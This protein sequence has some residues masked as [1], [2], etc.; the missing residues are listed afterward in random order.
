MTAKSAHSALEHL[1]TVWLLSQKENITERKGKLK[2]WEKCQSFESYRA[3]DKCSFTPILVFKN[4]GAW[5]LEWYFYKNYLP[6]F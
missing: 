1:S 2:V 4:Y 5:V 6:N 3:R